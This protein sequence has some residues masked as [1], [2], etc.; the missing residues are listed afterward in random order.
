LSDGGAFYA[1]FEVPP[2]LN[3]SD[4]AF[5]ELAAK[6]RVLLVPGS[7]FSARSTHVRLSFT[8]ED[9]LLDE[10]LAIVARLLQGA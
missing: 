1:F 4:Q 3:L 9:D 2:S 10:G 8:V 7:V 6:E 5:V